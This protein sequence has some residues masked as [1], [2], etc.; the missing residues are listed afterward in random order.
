M[1]ADERDT[2]NQVGRIQVEKQKKN[3][4]G[5]NRLETAGKSRRA[6]AWCG[7]ETARG[8]STGDCVPSRAVGSNR[9]RGA[10][11]RNQQ[12][13]L[14]ALDCLSRTRIADP[15]SRQAE[16]GR[17]RLLNGHSAT[18]QHCAPRLIPEA[19]SSIPPTSISPPQLP[20]PPHP[21]SHSA[22][23]PPAFSSRCARALPTPPTPPRASP[24]TARDQ[25]PATPS[26]IVPSRRKI[27][28]KHQPGSSP[29]QHQR[30]ARPQSDAWI[31]DS[32]A[33]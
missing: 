16:T 13:G 4:N 12:A 19:Q 9:P 30:A 24:P 33:A 6:P 7:S 32:T 8:P 28:P 10:I 20:Q 22:Q 5:R 18:A 23:L 1:T 31:V 27:S 3:Q 26:A 14:D 21:Y 17:K 25:P 29:Y 2:T 11:R 15:A